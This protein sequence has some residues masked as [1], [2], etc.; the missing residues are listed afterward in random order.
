LADQFIRFRRGSRPRTARGGFT[1]LEIA[2][3]IVILII[4]VAST[5]AAT[6]SLSAMRRLN[7]ERSVAHNA[8]SALAE[9]ILSLGRSEIGRPGSWARNVT[10]SVCPPNT[11]GVS[12][13]VSELEPQ[14]GLAHVGSI[15]F[16]TDET[17]T[18]NSLGVQLGM[19]RDLDGNGFVDG[20]NVI[21]TARLLP[22]VIELRWTGIR[23][24]QR[25]VHPFL[26]V[27][28]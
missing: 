23:G 27:G 25:L 15:T 17:R 3:T 19:P 21:A 4:A 18:D 24:E 22:V 8:A 20:T 10:E 14:T 13:D 26:V 12:F 7:R 11:L 16:V 2:I 5:S 28:Y 6:I 9:R 1:L